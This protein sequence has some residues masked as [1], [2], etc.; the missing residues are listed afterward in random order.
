MSLVLIAESGRGLPRN[1]ELRARLKPHL[2]AD[3][4]LLAALLVHLE[5]ARDDRAFDARRLG[6]LADD[7]ATP[8]PSDGD[9]D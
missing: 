1:R 4:E 9:A 7:L 5:L 6:E 3:P 2:D 8:L